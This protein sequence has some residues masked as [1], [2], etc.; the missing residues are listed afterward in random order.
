MPRPGP[1]LVWPRLFWH[2]K[3]QP[4]TRT[5]RLEAPR[6]DWPSW[7]QA[8]QVHLT[9][10]TGD[11]GSETGE[12]AQVLLPE[13]RSDGPRAVLPPRNAGG[14]SAFSLPAGVVGAEALVWVRPVGASPDFPVEADDRQGPTELQTQGQQVT[15]ASIRFFRCRD[16]WFARW[17]YRFED[18][19]SPY[20][21][22][23]TGAIHP[24]PPSQRAETGY[25]AWAEARLPAHRTDLREAWM[26]GDTSPIHHADVAWAGQTTRGFIRLGDP[27]TMLGGLWTRTGTANNW[28]FPRPLR[29]DLGQ[30]HGLHDLV[31]AG[32]VVEGI[33]QRLERQRDEYPEIYAAAEHL[34]ALLKRVDPSGDPTDT[35]PQQGHPSRAG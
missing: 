26:R 15:I 4:G 33:L 16:R 27:P 24:D 18:L 20:L 25:L 35:A 23:G 3:V 28:W 11:G 19:S 21:L 2:R 32:L 6:G 1:T 14:A 9:L 31:A 7:A 29:M 8:T 34:R 13:W 30:V 12:P 5:L 22:L 10:F 17:A